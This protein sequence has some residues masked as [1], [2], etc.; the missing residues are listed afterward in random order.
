MGDWSAAVRAHGHVTETFVVSI[1]HRGEL[2]GVRVDLVPV[3][4][5]VRAAS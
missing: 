2:R 4:E 1:P 5:R 3:R